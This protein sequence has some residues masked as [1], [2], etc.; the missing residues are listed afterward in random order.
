MKSDVRSARMRSAILGRPT[1]RSERVGSVVMSVLQSSVPN[2]PVLR[3]AGSGP[4]V[5]CGVLLGAVQTGLRP[6]DRPILRR[7]PLPLD[8]L[9]AVVEA[10]VVSDPDHDPG[11]PVRAVVQASGSGPH[12]VPPGSRGVRAHPA[13]EPS[14]ASGAVQ[15]A[16][17]PKEGGWSGPTRP[18]Q[19]AAAPDPNGLAD[20]PSFVL[21]S[22]PSRAGLRT[23]GSS[24]SAER[25]IPLLS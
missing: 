1:R 7:P 22:G 6:V 8:A 24:P 16:V 15:S 18:P 17:R 11:R 10:E 19:P 14:E 13:F 20:A 12:R 4:P 5:R 25:P 9:R 23:R 2:G 21:A 3:H